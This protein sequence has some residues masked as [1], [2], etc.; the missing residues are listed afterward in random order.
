MSLG[1]F[2]WS[3]SGFVGELSKTNKVAILHRLK[4]DTTSLPHLP[5][6]HAAITDDMAAIKK[7][8][9]NGL[10]FQQFADDLL[11]FIISG[12]RLASRINSF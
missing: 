12:T 5:H 3:L 7:A 1:P 8:K 11:Q 2:P 9:A 4:E 10:T 6:N